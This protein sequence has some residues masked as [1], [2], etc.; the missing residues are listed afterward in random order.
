MELKKRM[1]AIYNLWNTI[2]SCLLTISILVFWFLF[3]WP[4]L[5]AETSFKVVFILSCFSLPI[6]PG[7]FVVGLFDRPIKMIYFNSKEIVFFSLL[8]RTIKCD[9]SNISLC[10]KGFFFYMHSYTQPSV[11][12]YLE[13]LEIHSNITN[14]VN[15]ERTVIPYKCLF[16]KS[17]AKCQKRL[18]A[19]FHFLNKLKPESVE[20]G[21][22]QELKDK[23]EKYLKYNI[24]KRKIMCVESDSS[25]RIIEK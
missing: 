24:I 20:T 23:E 4:N 5:I 12:E 15:I 6:I 2:V 18:N 10:K 14:G 13:C 16:T 3:I 11:K 21:L 7:I 22:I 19:L 1:I 25:I 17:K 9:I 8:H